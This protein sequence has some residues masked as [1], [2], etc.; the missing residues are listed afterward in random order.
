MRNRRMPNGTYGGVL[1]EL[2]FN[3]NFLLPMLMD[4]GRSGGKSSH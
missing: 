3:A 4:I 1:C 2:L